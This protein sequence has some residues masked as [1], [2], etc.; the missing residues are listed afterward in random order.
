MASLEGILSKKAIIPT[1]LSTVDDVSTT[2]HIAV[3]GP[4]IDL[5]F[6]EMVLESF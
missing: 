1:T 3:N 5:P 4:E 6:S 2:F